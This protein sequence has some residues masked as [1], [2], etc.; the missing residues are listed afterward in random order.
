[1]CVYTHD[2]PGG[3]GGC[4]VVVV[5]VVVTR[6][7]VRRGRIITSAVRRKPLA[8]VMGPGDLSIIVEIAYTYRPVRSR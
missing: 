2:V 5:V 3:V 4:I 8:V 1:M 7:L 6:L